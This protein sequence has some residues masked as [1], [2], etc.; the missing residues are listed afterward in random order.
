MT[1]GSNSKMWTGKH[2][3]LLLLIIIAI[4]LVGWR[5]PS[6][7]FSIEAE[8]E[9]DLNNMTIPEKLKNELKTGEPPISENAIVAKEKEDKWEII[10]GKKTYI[11]EKKDGKLNVYPPSIRIL[12]AWLAFLILL[13]AFAVI[14]GHGVTGMWWGLL[15]DERN[16]ISLSRLQ[17]ILW[18][19]IILS[20]FLTVALANI[21]A[22]IDEP[23]SISI[24]EELWLL[25]GI[26]TASLVG[27]P[28]ILSTKK[29]KEPKKEEQ[30]QTINSMAAEE[31]VSP[32]NLK[33]KVTNKGQV[34]VNKDPKDARLSDLFKGE[35]T[36]NAAQLDLGKIQMF[37]FTL[38][39]VL[40]YAVALGDLLC[41]TGKIDAFP[42][43][44]ASMVALLGISHAGYLTNKAIP[45]SQGK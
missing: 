22:G 20:G 3:F 41:G 19:V 33:S 42:V 29:V 43:L 12:Y 4:L 6:N 38:I 8:F 5:I 27:S 34:I 25:M 35:E 18:T 11:V 45:H 1:E 23:L 40:A 30:D 9:D 44:S 21:A 13:I 31:G 14:A 16:K 24:P 32:K 37:Y 10:D 2:T 39:I 15:I 17:M 36:G 28:L 7:S 26:S